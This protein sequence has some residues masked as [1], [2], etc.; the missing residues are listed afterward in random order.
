VGGPGTRPGPFE[1]IV[2]SRR[3]VIAAVVTTAIGGAVVPSFAQSAPSLPVTVTTDTH[4]GV[5][6]GVSVGSQ[7]GAG[8]SVTPDGKA[9]VGISLQLPVCAGGGIQTG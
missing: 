7:P 4:N 1:G 8:A 5:S 6:V 9:C 3:I 2:V